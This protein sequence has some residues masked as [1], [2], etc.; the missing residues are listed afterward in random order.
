METKTPAA[1]DAA[2]RLRAAR[3]Q[4]DR[5]RYLSDLADARRTLGSGHTPLVATPLGY[6]RMP[7]TPATRSP[8]RRAAERR[9]ENRHVQLQV[10]LNAAARGRLDLKAM[11]A[12]T[13]ALLASHRKGTR[14]MTAGM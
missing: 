14:R 8:P 4:G 12:R 5:Q 3:F 7:R 11:Q 9:A 1:G 6:V 13:A 10:R 2:A